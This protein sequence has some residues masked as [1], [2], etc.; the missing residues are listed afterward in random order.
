MRGNL[1]IPGGW[2][3]I[4][5]EAGSPRNR[6]FTGL[7][8]SD[9][10]FDQ[11]RLARAIWTEKC[12][13]RVRVDPNVQVFVK[14]VLFEAGVGECHVTEGDDGGDKLSTLGKAK[15]EQPILK[16][17]LGFRV[18]GLEFRVE[19]PHSGKRSLSSQS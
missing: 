17:G 7:Q 8:I 19:V 9:H 11:R 6:P 1:V 3:K 18:S 10:Q 2:S 5:P 16:W 14:V 15:L 13:P 12:N 4:S